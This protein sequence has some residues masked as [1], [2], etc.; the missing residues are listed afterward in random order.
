MIEHL[1]VTKKYRNYADTLL[2]LGLV[3]LVEYALRQTNQKSDVGLFDEGMR[4]RIQLK[5]A[6]NLQAIAKLD[7][8]NPFPPVKGQKTDT[9]KIPL[10]IEP[11]DT[12]KESEKRKLYKNYVFQQRDKPQWNEEAPKPPHASTQNGVI[13]TSMRHDRNHNELWHLGYQLKENYGALLV[14]LFQAFSEETSS[15]PHTE[16]NRCQEL[17]AQ[18]TNCKLPELASAVKIY[19]PTSVRGVNRVK[20]DSNKVDSQKADWLSLWLIAGGLFSFGVSERVK[21][22]DRVFEWRV[23]VLEPQDIQLSKYREVLDRLRKYNPPSGGHGI[24]RFDAELVLRFCQELLNNHASQADAE[25]DEF[26]IWEPINHFVKSFVGTHFGS[27]GQVYGVK[28]VFSLGL[29][30]WIRPANSQELADY[31]SVLQEH[32]SVIS[33]LSAEEGHSELLTA[34]RDFITG[35]SLRQ[36]FPFQ[37]SYA[38]YVIKRLADPKAKPP[39]LFSVTGLNTM[40]KKDSDFIKI[41]QDPS[42][43]RIAKAINQATVYAGKIQTKEG[44][45]ELEWQRTY[46]LAQRLSSQSGSKNDFLKEITDFLAKY[47][48]ENLRLSEQ[49]QGKGKSLKRVWTTKEDLDRLVEL[50]TENDTVLVANLLI[51]YGYARWTKPK[52]DLEPD[53]QQDINE[54]DDTAILG[55]SNDD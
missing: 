23:V 6:V 19:L 20:A 55:E 39:R 28:E 18:A 15:Q 25:L 41:T 34:Y 35:T 4:Y 12:V 27:K 52:D 53:Q 54:L 7:Y 49:L 36:F 44:V 51:A 13:L 33:T 48:A 14:A 40:T 46:G 37:V 42:F 24:A 31:Q 8:T 11:F 17:F 21:I 26:D 47:E 16:A 3:Q 29:P 5:Q 32:L 1:F 43:L 9:S 50:V 10:E 22:A 2:L 30:G 45:K 38:D